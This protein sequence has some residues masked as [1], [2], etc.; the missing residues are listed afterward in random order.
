MPE[1]RKRDHF[2]PGLPCASFMKHIHRK[3]GHGC[4][5]HPLILLTLCMKTGDKKSYTY[6]RNC[7]TGYS[8]DYHRVSRRAHILLSTNLSRVPFQDKDKRGTKCSQK[9]SSLLPVYMKFRLPFRSFLSGKF[10]VPPKLLL[11]E[12]PENVSN[13]VRK[14]VGF[15]NLFSWFNNNTVGFMGKKKQKQNPQSSPSKY[16]G[17]RVAVTGTVAY[18]DRLESVA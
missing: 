18:L 5:P 4:A 14:V 15:F 1:L 9:F 17:E 2:F 8:F 7:S 12:E 11:P 10:I 16:N 6:G 3:T 13:S